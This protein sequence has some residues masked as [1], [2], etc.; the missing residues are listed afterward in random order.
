MA[1]ASRK[2]IGKGAQGK[3]Q[4][5][6]AMTTM[7]PD[8]IGENMILSNSDK[9]HRSAERGLDSRHIM[10][11]QAQDHVHN[12]IPDETALERDEAQARKEPR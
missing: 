8:T 5:S 10:N 9:S 7:P 11:E 3:G 6:G 4:G 1:N 2:K 12:R